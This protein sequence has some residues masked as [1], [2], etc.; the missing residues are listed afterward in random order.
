[1]YLPKASKYAHLMF[2]LQVA[3]TQE[4]IQVL[5]HLSIVLLWYFVFTNLE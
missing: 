5:E 4:V 2:V 3:A 1:M